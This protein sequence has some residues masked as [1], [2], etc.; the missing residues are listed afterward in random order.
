MEGNNPGLIAA[1]DSRLSEDDSSQARQPLLPPADTDEQRQRFVT[2]TSYLCMLV[3]D[4]V[5]TSVIIW[6]I[7]MLAEY[8]NNL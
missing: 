2:V 8:V 6:L 1:S 3:S 7:A 4:N 5:V